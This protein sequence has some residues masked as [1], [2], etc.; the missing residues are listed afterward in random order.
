MVVKL[1]IVTLIKGYEGTKWEL[2]SGMILYV[3]ALIC[4]RRTNGA[5][6]QRKCLV[7]IRAVILKRLEENV[8]I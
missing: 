1:I 7:C 8:Y 5:C 3:F 6:F 2:V 4:R